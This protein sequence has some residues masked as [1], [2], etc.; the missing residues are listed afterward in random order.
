MQAPAK[1][2][3]QCIPQK[4]ADAQDQPIGKKKEKKREI[5][6]SCNER[7]VSAFKL[8]DIFEHTQTQILLS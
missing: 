8:R 1:Q 6:S 7:V 2:N 3:F 4:A 5:S